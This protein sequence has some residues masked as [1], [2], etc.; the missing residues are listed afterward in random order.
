MVVL[1]GIYLAL[2]AAVAL[3]SYEKKKWLIAG[4]LGLFLCSACIGLPPGSL[5]DHGFEA[6]LEPQPI[7]LLVLW[8]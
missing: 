6:A 1:T 4:F 8:Y 5:A 7:A 3:P 2:Y